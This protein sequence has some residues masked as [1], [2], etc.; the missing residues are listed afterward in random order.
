MLLG[1]VETGGTTVRCARGTG[2]DD[3]GDVV[4]FPTGTPEQT[5]ARVLAHFAAGPRVAAVGVGAFGPIEV[6]PASP[7]WG[8]LLRTPKPGWSGFGLGPALRDGLGVPV[9]LDSDVNAAALAEG[10]S[11]AAVG[12]R[13][14][15][16]VTVGTGIGLGVLTEAGPLHGLLHPE[17]GHL[18]VPRAPGDDFAGSC[19][20]HGDCWEGLAG[21]LAVAARWGA[22]P[23]TLPEEHP[24]W[25][26]EAGYVAA[27]IAAIVL[28]LSPRRV[29]LGGGVGS[30]PG[31]LAGVRR[32]LPGLLAGAL[33]RP[34]DEAAAAQLVVARHHRDAGLA[35]AMVLAAGAVAPHAV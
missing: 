6:D 7:R 5:V 10:T 22:D 26:L 15:A 4:S 31:V 34:A 28:V 32:R 33:D 30:R 25:A 2:P 24:A 18:R 14:A 19:P 16:Y 3:L 35:G 1:A 20:H 23:S 21:G 13:P 17:A 11:G 12:V 9:A 27:G 8:H 29:V